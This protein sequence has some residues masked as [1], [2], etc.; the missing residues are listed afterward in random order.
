MAGIE[1]VVL[2]N[3]DGFSGDDTGPDRTCTGA[4]LR[5]FR[6]EIE[7]CLAQLIVKGRVAHE[8]D[9][10]AARIRQKQHV[11]LPG[12]LREEGFKAGTADADQLFGLLAMFAQLELRERY[13][14]PARSSDPACN[15]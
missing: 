15:R 11:I 14:L 12:D 4:V 3:D 10:D 8:I 9:G 5:P 2:M 13:R 1:M 7:A 6:A